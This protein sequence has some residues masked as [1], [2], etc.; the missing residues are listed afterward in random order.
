MR[1]SFFYYCGNIGFHNVIVYYGNVIV[2]T[3]SLAE[4]RNKSLIDLD[5]YDLFIS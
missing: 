1:A 4:Y 3:E 5:G 2:F